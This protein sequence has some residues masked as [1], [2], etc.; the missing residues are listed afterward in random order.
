MDFEVL[1]TQRRGHAEALAREAAEAGDGLVVAA[2]GDGTVH[3]VA[4][5]LVGT[6]TALGIL[7]CGSGNGLARALRMPLDLRRACRAL[8]NTGVRRIDAGRVNGRFF[9]AT[10]GTG[11][12]ALVAA[13]YDERPGKRR[14]LLP[15]VVLTART[16]LACVPEEVTLTL[17][18]G[19]PLT[20]RPLLLTVANTRQY[21]GGAIIA[22]NA[23]PDDG[24]LDVCL[25]ENISPFR[26]LLH[27]PRLF[28]GAIHRMP[29][30]RLF[31]AA[32]VQIVRQAPG[33]FQMDGEALQGEAILNV[34]VVPGALKV[35]A[36]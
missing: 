13:R 25:M 7:P 21:G 26:A 11:L 12:D 22:P 6:D 28:T 3:E 5:G 36:P 1:W 16:F 14:G 20:A 2:G 8:L 15:Y 31:Q 17:D 30:V 18:H 9:F 34:E 19:P 27:A 29:G 32:A 4:S 24:L 23:R 35:A 33:P 10:A